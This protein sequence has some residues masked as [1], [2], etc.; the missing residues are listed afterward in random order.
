MQY[1][2]TGSSEFY[3]N[4][5][6]KAG[7]WLLVIGGII[8]GG[9]GWWWMAALA[10]AAASPYGEQP[11]LIFPISTITGAI[12]AIAGVF[13]VSIGRVLRH[14]INVRVAPNRD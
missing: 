8:G 11:P 13:M 14:D 3:F 12:A 7:I 10:Q 6:G 9:M 5:T 1:Y 4:G 2:V